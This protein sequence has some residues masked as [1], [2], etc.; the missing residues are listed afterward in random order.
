MTEPLEGLA[1]MSAF[2]VVT[3]DHVS[4]PVPLLV[5]AMTADADRPISTG[6]KARFPVREMEAGACGVDGVVGALLESRLHETPIAASRSS[7]TTHARRPHVAPPLQ[8]V[9]PGHSRFAG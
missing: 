7:N 1:V 8:V 2:P 4:V 6:P 5:M 3:P 9:R